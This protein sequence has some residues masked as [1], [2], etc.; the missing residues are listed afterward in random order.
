MYLFSPADP[1]RSIRLHHDIMSGTNARGVF[2][3]FATLTVYMYPGHTHMN[4]R[5]VICL[6]LLLKRSVFLASCKHLYFAIVMELCTCIFKCHATSLSIKHSQY[7]CFRGN[8]NASAVSITV[9]VPSW[10]S[11]HLRWCL[12]SCCKMSKSHDIDPRILV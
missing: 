10:W 4:I 7:S 5:S 3:L 11:F 8:L 6:K 12:L 2:S 9:S 1:F